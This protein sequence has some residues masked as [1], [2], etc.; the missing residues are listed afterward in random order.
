MKKI[1]LLSSV[2]LMIATQAWAYSFS[3]VASSGQTLY[4]NITSAMIPGMP[5]TVAV[6]YPG[7]SSSDPYSGYT[8][9]IG[10][11]TIP[12][13]VSYNGTTYTVAEIGDYAFLSCTN[14]MGSLSLPNTITRIGHYAFNGCTGFTGVLTLPDGITII[15]TYAFQNCHF[16][17]ALLLPAALTEVSN[18][19][20]AGCTGFTSVTFPNNINRIGNHAFDNC[21]GLTGVL[22]IPDAVTSIGWR[23]FYDCDHITS[24][25]TGNGVQII[26]YGAFCHCGALTSLVIGDNVHRIYDFAFY[27]CNYLTTVTLG[28]SLEHLDYSVFEGC[29]S[30]AAITMR[31]N[32]PPITTNSYRPDP[33]IVMSIDKGAP[34]SGYTGGTNDCNN[35]SYYYYICLD[36]HLFGR[37]FS[38]CSQVTVLNYDSTA[39]I[40]YLNSHRFYYYF[41]GALYNT[42][43]GNRPYYSTFNNL[44]T[45]AIYI[46]VPC[47]AVSSY[48]SSTDWSGFNV[49]GYLSYALQLQ[50]NADSM[51]TVALTQWP[52]CT[53]P[54]AIFVAS[55]ENNYHFV[56]WSDGVTDN[57]RT[58]TV[59]QDT[60]FTAIFASNWVNVNV[61]PNHNDYG[62]VSG[63]GTYYYNTT[64]TLQ[65]TPSAHYHFV[66]WSDGNTDNPRSISVDNDIFLTAVFAID[67]HTLVVNTIDSTRGTVTGGGVYDYGT[68]VFATAYAQTGH[69]FTQWND[70]VTSNPRNVIVTSDTSFTAHFGIYSYTVVAAANDPLK[71]SVTGGGTYDYGSQIVLTAVPNIGFCFVQWG[72]GNTETPRVVTVTGNAAYTA[73]FALPLY[74]IT[75]LNSTPQWGQVSGGGTY[76]M[77]DT[78]ILT[79]TPNTGY[80]LLQWSDGMTI[81]PKTVV[82]S[83]DATYTAMFAPNTYTLT[84]SSGNVAQ[85]TVTGSGTYDYNTSVI[86]S[87]TANYGYHFTQ[88]SDGNTD[89]PRVVSVTEDAS[90]VAMFAPNNYILTVSSDNVNMGNVYGS[91]VYEYNAT[92]SI[93]ATANNGY[94]FT[95]WSDGNTS[96]PRTVMVTNEATYIAYFAADT[97]TIVVNSGNVDQGSAT[98][99]GTYDFNSTVILSATPNYGYH[100]YQWAD[101]NLTNPR[102]VTVTGD[103]VYTALFAPNS[104]TLTV[105]SVDTTKGV[106]VGSGIYDYNTSVTLVATALTGYHFTQWNDGNTQSI[107][108]VVVTQDASYQ[109][110]FAAD[111]YTVMAIASDSTQG[112]VTGGGEYEYGGQAILQANP[113]QHHHFIQWSDGNNQNPRVVTVI[114]NI[115]LVAMFEADPQFTITVVSDNPER[116]SVSGG[117]TFYSGEQTMITANAFDHFIF[118]HWSDG[119]TNNPKTVT[120]VDNVTYTAYFVGTT[121]NVSVFSNDDNLGSVTGSG[122]YEYG[123][124]ATV[125]ATPTA[126]N[127]FVRWSNGAEENPYTFTVYNDVNLIA[128]FQQGVGIQDNNKDDWYLF[129]QNGYILLRNIPSD[130]PV[131]VYDMLGKLLYFTESVDESEMRIPVPAAGVYLVQVGDQSFKKIVVTK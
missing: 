37:T 124:S 32:T 3:A 87:A 36:R 42:P 18:W 75:V 92:V 41:K 11:L 66:E 82:V 116:G 119:S 63:S 12:S 126:G 109:A 29:T 72:D 78:V 39:I 26:Y 22:N 52:T 50:A 111:T 2:I 51:G 31:R 102:I 5:Q 60:S 104:Y 105:S 122:S 120:V 4:Y 101:S 57:P 112:S 56:G 118:D 33:N 68:S 55:P 30:L 81:N 106:V 15:G 77:G 93:S 65:A 96:N 34:F 74:T 19:S 69:Y 38:T 88:W 85:G 27:G 71:G 80:H 62:S 13:T 99:G 76:S 43:S 14:L 84:V 113:A 94:H 20:F 73:I 61:S 90:F 7:T 131:G 45:S 115:S 107:R 53:D 54:T 44:N 8:K 49:Q 98:G 129:A 40:Q 10:N 128:T 83:Q 23:A 16:T 70:G 25:N 100:F 89:N 127:H 48:Q 117:G 59:T 86:L 1:L 121:H 91:G 17:G 108:F 6:T 130:K 21:D 103:A 67:Q 125:T 9:P 35:G 95:Q 24:V 58:I 97:Y 64:V 47:S 79:A 46:H 28:Q 123:S 110:F 114:Q